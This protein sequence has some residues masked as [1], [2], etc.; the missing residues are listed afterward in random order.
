MGFKA[1]LQKLRMAKAAELLAGTRLPVATVARRVGY[2]N[3]S[4]F[5]AH[6]VRAR[7]LPPRAWRGKNTAPALNAPAPAGRFGG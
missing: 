2:R 5:A 3:F 4:L 1:Y 7:G 6:F